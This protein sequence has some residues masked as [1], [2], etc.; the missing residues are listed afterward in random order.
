M[1]ES[2]ETL[3][4]VYCKSPVVSKFPGSEDLIICDLCKSKH[5][6]DLIDD[7]CISSASTDPVE[8]AEVLMKSPGFQMHCPDH[9]YLVP[10]VLL[11]SYSKKTRKTKKLKSWL[12]IARNRAEKVPGA[13][14]GTHGSCGAAVGTGIFMSTVLGATPLS[15][16]EWDLCNSIVGRSLLS[17]APYGGPRC[18]KRV[19]YLSLQEASAFVKERLSIQL[20]IPEEIECKFYQK[21][22]EQCMKEKCPF[23]PN[24]N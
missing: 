19:T 21:N 16:I 14:C 24:I 3:P 10:A 6:R 22:E 12:K 20:T 4:C 23:Y 8:I 17:M 9:H 15:S 2:A 7:Y 1:K 5:P 13:F 18:C 11:A